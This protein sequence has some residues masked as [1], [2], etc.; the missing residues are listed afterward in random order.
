[1]LPPTSDT[2]H[3]PPS[4]GW[5]AGQRFVQAPAALTGAPVGPKLTLAGTLGSSENSGVSEPEAMQWNAQDWKFDP[6]AMR[7]IPVVRDGKPLPGKQQGAPAPAGVDPPTNTAA[8][9][10]QQPAKLP[11]LAMASGSRSKGHPTCQVATCETDLTP[12]K[13]YHQRYK[14]CEFH[15]KVHSIVREG[16][17]QRFCQQCGRFHDLTEFDG[18]K[19]SCRARLQRHNARRRK[20]TEAEAAKSA[21]VPKKPTPGPSKRPA[22][23]EG[24]PYEGA[25]G[26]EGMELDESFTGM[27]P[28]AG[29]RAESDGILDASGES[30][31]PGPAELYS[32]RPRSL[33]APHFEDGL[34]NHLLDGQPS[35]YGPRSPAGGYMMP[36]ERLGPGPSFSAPFPTNRSGQGPT[37]NPADY[38]VRPGPG[39]AQGG[40]S[41]LAGLEQQQQ[42][43]FSGSRSV[44]AS[45][46]QR[47]SGPRGP[48]MGPPDSMIPA[49][50]MTETP[51]SIM[52]E[53][54]RI[55]QA[56]PE[57]YISD[58]Q[59]SRVSAKLFNCTPATLPLDMKQN[60]IHL[61]GRGVNSMEG[62]IR[63]GCVHITMNAITNVQPGQDS[64]REFEEGE[65]RNG[66]DIRS[67]IARMQEA[68]ASLLDTEQLL[69]QVE[70]N[71]PA[72]TIRLFGV[73]ITHADNTFLCRC[74]GSWVSPAITFGLEANVDGQPVPQPYAELRFEQGMRNG[75][76]HV[77]VM[78][79]GMTSASK[80]ILLLDSAVAVQEMKRL[81]QE[82]S[83]AELEALL[84]DLDR[85]LELRNAAT[86][87]VCQS[88]ECT[89]VYTEAELEHVVGLAQKVLRFSVQR[90]CIG[91]AEYVF[92]VAFAS[93]ASD[94]EDLSLLHL[95]VRSSSLS[96]V[97][98]LISRASIAGV[99]LHAGTA[100]VNGIT[101]LH[102]AALFQ[103]ADAP[104][105]RM[106]ELLAGLCED[107]AS[108]WYTASAHGRTPADFAAAV[109][110]KAAEAAA[111]A[112]MMQA[113]SR[114]RHA[115]FA[116]DGW[117]VDGTTGETLCL[118][119]QHSMALLRTSSLDSLASDEDA[120][121]AEEPVAA[122]YPQ[123][124]QSKAEQAV[125]EGAGPAT[126]DMRPEAAIAPAT[127]Q[128]VGLYHRAKQGVLKAEEVGAPSEKP[129]RF[130]V[131]G[132]DS[133][134]TKPKSQ[135]KLQ[136]SALGAPV[137][138]TVFGHLE[139][140]ISALCI[141]TIGIATLSVRYYFEYLCDTAM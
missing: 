82:I 67:V 6:Y 72:P 139:A 11:A 140:V 34:N 51:A 38:L 61:L 17:R 92:P 55:M 62:Y 134:E 130:V 115:D 69:I 46:F 108:A 141:A 76:I 99:E 66:M 8:Q 125:L 43:G 22:D 105:G 103:E 57:N 129:A 36:P 15:L 58:E 7:A 53:A 39:M 63:P 85:L 35:S 26:S 73:N 29:R 123:Q 13:E 3:P 27:M 100:G 119:V 107:G 121:E 89:R 68:N 104:S 42:Q 44:D 71:L 4:G 1:M 127:P 41:L 81:Q 80:P 110:N 90:S 78:R 135:D 122:S 87:V 131:P 21:A 114:L 137:S 109:A 40:Q 128:K 106:V 28:N 31:G 25:P 88:Q 97:E 91:L 32:R 102:L 37:Q 24:R 96:M 2:E 23:A 20:K 5:P 49:F 116:D 98:W 70:C 138:P 10:S 79:G 118:D 65:E 113:P 52:N 117:P 59:L 84:L 9:A 45:S 14:I 56:P 94:D 111:Q 86:A 33:P 18:D 19:R 133:L 77:E 54:R 93:K 60:L 47:G 132:N 75:L 12:L 101:P 126:P 83:G 112:S 95:A 136:G 48:N 64:T 124:E 50:S 30:S 16:K 74:Q 120:L